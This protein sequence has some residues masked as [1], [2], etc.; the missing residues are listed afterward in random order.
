M[1]VKI[2]GTQVQHS[3]GG[4]LGKFL[5]TLA[6]AA[7]GFFIGG[8][9]GALKGASLGGGL[10]GAAGGALNPGQAAEVGIPVEGAKASGFGPAKQE[11]SAI[12]RLNSVLSAGQN[13][14]GAASSFGDLSKPKLTLGAP[15]QDPSNPFTRRLNQRYV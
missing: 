1:S 5:G 8:P 6:G 13:I 12:D 4:G 7:G 14:A 3:G 11:P 15:I 2:D 9:A 10:G